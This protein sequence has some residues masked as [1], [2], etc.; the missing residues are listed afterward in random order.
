MR[1]KHSAQF[2]Q[3]SHCGHAHSMLDGPPLPA[4]PL[5]HH[6]VG[7]RHGCQISTSIA[8]LPAPNCSHQATCLHQATCSPAPRPAHRLPVHL[9]LRLLTD[10]LFTCPCACSQTNCSPAPAPAHRLTVCLPMR[11]PTD[12]LFTCPCAC[13]QST[14]S[15]ALSSARLLPTAA[16]DYPSSWLACPHPFCQHPIC[17]HPPCPQPSCL[18]PPC[19]QPSCLQ[20]LSRPRLHQA[21]RVLVPGTSFATSTK[22][23][24]FMSR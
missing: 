2:A 5:L 11:L 7:A 20:Q 24:G 17:L 4:L 14:C 12:D 6:F 18:H 19:L 9:L 15:P 8:C 13:P 10:Y 22:S 1:R 21:T 3:P 16:S 23:S